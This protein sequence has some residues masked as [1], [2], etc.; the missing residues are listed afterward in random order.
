MIL[1]L[2][3]ID[4]KIFS[5]YLGGLIK[6]MGWVEHFLLGRKSE[7]TAKKVT[8]NRWVK[9]FAYE[10]LVLDQL[11]SDLEYRAMS[12]MRACVSDVRSFL[13]S[14][15]TSSRGNHKIASIYYCTCK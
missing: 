1:K 5:G 15:C 7:K 9:F 8:W 13:C 6:K 4:R 14:V 10:K 3:E 2:A 11:N 12:G